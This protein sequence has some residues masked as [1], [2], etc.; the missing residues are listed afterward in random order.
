LGQ[1]ITADGH[2]RQSYLHHPEPERV[3]WGTMPRVCRFCGRP[4]ESWEPWDLDH[5]LGREGGDWGP[6]A[7]AHRRC[8]RADGAERAK[9]SRRASRIERHLA[10]EAE[11]EYWLEESLAPRAPPPRH[12][13][14]AR[15]PRIY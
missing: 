15:T 8:N 3:A 12:P 13:G 1:V 2:A 5:V 7:L 6:V 9:A 11:R 4:I 14:P 10:D